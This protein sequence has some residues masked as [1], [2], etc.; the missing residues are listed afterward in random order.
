MSEPIF[1]QVCLDP[2]LIEGVYNTCD[3]WC[4][5]C[6]VTA[7]CLA[8]RCSPEIRSG[9]QDIQKSLADRL[10]EGI[11]FVKRLSE[12][13]GKP[14]PELDAMLADDPRTR[15]SVPPVDD[16]LERA[17]SRYARLSHAYLVSRDDYP[18][19]MVWRPSGPT[20][21]EVLAWF[22]MLIAVKIYR[23]LWCSAAAARG[24][25][26]RKD[27]ALISAKV[28]LI[29]ID[30]SLVAV[31]ALSVADDDER[32]ESLASQLRRLRREVDARFPEARAFVR[33]GLD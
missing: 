4:M 20:P 10:Y 14:T 17:G 12:A 28:A 15:T 30:R 22:H 24:D 29:G 8:Y 2:T 3:Q 26:S 7:R 16:P 1:N 25:T 33:E 27:D 13:E 9:K 19:E 21:I 32:L 6:P 5:Y 11:T 23:A 18:F 31:C